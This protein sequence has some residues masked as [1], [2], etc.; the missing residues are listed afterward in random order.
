VLKRRFV[1]QGMHLDFRHP[2]IA[3]TK[4]L[5]HL[6]KKFESRNWIRSEINAPS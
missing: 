4:L 5:P 6:S 2:Q 3:D 1:G